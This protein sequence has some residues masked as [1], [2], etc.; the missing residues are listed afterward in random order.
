MQGL[1]WRSSA[2]QK[3]EE[4]VYGTVSNNTEQQQNK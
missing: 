2:D 1:S 3:Y 4:A